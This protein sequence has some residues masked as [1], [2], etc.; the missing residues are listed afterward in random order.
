MADSF[1]TRVKNLRMA[2]DYSQ[3][4][5]AKL[6]EISAGLVSFIERDRNRPNYEIVRRLANVLETSTDY[7]ITGNTSVKN[8]I[9]QLVHQ[10]LV[11]TGRKRKNAKAARPRKS[12]PGKITKLAPEDQALIQNV[13]EK[14]EYIRKRKQK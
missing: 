4:D 11:E 5:L 10:H 12:L 7:L 1:G 13:V 9:N 14:I 8:T 6:A 2:L 3:R